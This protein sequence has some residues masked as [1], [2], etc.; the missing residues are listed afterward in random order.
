M[1]AHCFDGM[2]CIPNCDKIVP[3]MLMAAMRVDMPAVFVSGGP[4]PAGETPD[5]RTVDLISVFEGVGAYKAG[6]IDRGRTDRR[7][8]TSPARPADRAAA[9]SPPTA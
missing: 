2:I 5:G 4:M 1:P 3:G 7:W 8:K 9:C 6:K